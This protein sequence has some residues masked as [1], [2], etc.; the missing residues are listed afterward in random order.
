MNILVAPDSFKGSLSAERFCQIAREA[1]SRRFASGKITCIPMA[2]GGEGTCRAMVLAKGGEM[3]ACR[4]T[5]PMGNKISAQY[6]VLGGKEAVI[7]MAA[8]SGLPLVPEEK[9]D[10]F[11]ATSRGTGELILAALGTGAKMIY[12]GIGGSATNDGGAGML[13]ALGARLLDKDGHPVP[14]GARGLGALHSIDLTRVNPAAQ[15]AEFIVACD[16]DAVLCGER[17][18]SAVFG[19]QKGAKPEDIPLLDAWLSRFGDLLRGATGRDVGTIPGSGAAGGM[20]AALMAVLNARLMPGFA[21]VERVCGLEAVLNSG[22]FDVMITGEGQLSAQSLMG[23]LPV[24][25]ARLA[26]KYGVP[27]HA[28]VGSA[29]ADSQEAR[30]EFAAVTELQ[31]PGMSAEYSMQNAEALLAGALARIEL[32][33]LSG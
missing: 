30:R 13:A 1:L 18:A 25:A 29:A 22:R 26:R 11:S 14:D 32:P 9:R 8:A 20:G 24:E 6:G 28:V 10:I 31:S 4:V 7:E 12:M 5:A 2:D 23:K 21:A 17:G 15:D 3:A 33:G 27:T 19:P 16:V